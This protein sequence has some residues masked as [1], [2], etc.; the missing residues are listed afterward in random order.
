MGKI[1]D[2]TG[3]RFHKLTVL[4]RSTN[5]PK[6]TKEIPW[7]CR[8]TCGTTKEVSG[9]SLRTGHTKSCGCLR[10]EVN[11]NNSTTHSLSGTS[12]Y[13]AWI[14]M[15]SRCYNSK[16]KSYKNYGARGIT[17]C[18]KWMK[19]FINFYHDM[20]D[21]PSVK[22]TLER[23]DNNGIYSPKNC[24]WATRTEQGNNKR[25]CHI[26]K[27][28]KK[29]QTIS[30]WAMETGISHGCIKQRIKRGWSITDTLTV[31]ARKFNVL[32]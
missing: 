5:K 31:P 17:V 30:Q 21:K 26:I 22:H 16:N 7:V 24:I 12:V 2:I 18:D 19:S 4:Y 25:N 15:R 20:G 6:K 8:C 1:I 32:K 23:M 11:I 9:Y 13:N 10:S 29:A 28:N 14:G 3:K 27:F